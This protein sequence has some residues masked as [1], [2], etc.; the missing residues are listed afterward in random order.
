MRDL[1]ED[2]GSGAGDPM[3][4]ARRNM[5]PALRARFFKAAEVGEPAADGRVPIL[6]DGRA[7]QTPARRPLA[8]PTAALAAAVAAEW[9]RQTDVI[10]P[11]RMPLTRLANAII[12]GVADAPAPVAE[13][14][15]KYLGSDLLFY[16]AD[17]PAGLVAAQA[18][19]WDPLLAWAQEAFGARFMLAEGVVHVAQPD[20][21]IAAVR[22]GLPADPWRLGA[23]H[24]ITTLTGSALIAL[25]L[26]HGAISAEQGWT[27]AHVD[28]DWN[29]EQWGRDTLALQ[30]RAFRWQ[31]R[32]AAAL[33]LSAL[34]D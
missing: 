11:A 29:A 5:R 12:D 8:A 15:A 16:R 23:M 24:S 13:E 6:L 17:V 7:V 21:A 22:A 4:S 25:A 10:D 33:V 28:E 26:A 1:L 20:R 31:D 19:Q 27:A 14:I 9:D 2:L 34:A 3:G 32:Q 18:A 30:R